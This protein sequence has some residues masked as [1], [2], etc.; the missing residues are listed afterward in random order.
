MLSCGALLL[1]AEVPIREVHVDLMLQ[2]I[3]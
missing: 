2:G 3:G 1:L